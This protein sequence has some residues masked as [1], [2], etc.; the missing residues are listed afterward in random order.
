MFEMAR[1]MARW[2]Y[3][4]MVIHQFLPAVVGKATADSVYKEVENKAPI[5]NLKYYKPKNRTGRPFIPVEFAVAAYRFGHSMTGPAT[6]SG[7]L[8]QP[9]RRPREVTVSSVPLFERPG[10]RQQLERAPRLPLGSRFSGAS[11]STTRW[12]KKTMER[13]S[14]LPGPSGS[15]TLR[16]PTRCSNC[17]R[18]HYPTRPSR[19]SSRCAT[20]TGAE[21]WA[22]RRDSRWLG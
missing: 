7:T 17:R 14:S 6:P 16:W 18:R 20:S 8:R 9:Q 21:R 13:R 19:A 1:R 10:H 3:Q 22:C 4:W 15:S 11:S 2:H 5:I 12:R